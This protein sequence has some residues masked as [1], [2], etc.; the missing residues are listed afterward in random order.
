MGVVGTPP[1]HTVHPQTLEEV[2][3]LGLGPGPGK[4]PPLLGPEPGPG[5]APDTPQGLVRGGLPQL[6]YRAESTS[7]SSHLYSIHM[8]HTY[9]L[10]DRLQHL[11]KH[12]GLIH[13]T[14]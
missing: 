7:I 11:T 2:P 8:I 4:A 12:L 14:H 9:L 10:Q 3:L 6:R 5:A 1:V 13:S